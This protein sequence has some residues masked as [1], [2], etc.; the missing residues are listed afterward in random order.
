MACF[1]RSL[2][3]TYSIQSQDG[4]VILRNGRMTHLW[5]K[6]LPQY[7][8]LGETGSMLPER[9]LYRVAWYFPFN[10]SFRQAKKGDTDVS[11]F[12]ILPRPN[13]FYY[14]QALQFIDKPYFFPA[15]DASGEI[16]CGKI[17][18]DQVPE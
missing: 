11:P 3:A 5:G 15:P 9:E 17:P 14:Q 7:Q 4:L 13:R 18:I 10:G 16:L 1:W 6:A 12:F 8:R 2:K